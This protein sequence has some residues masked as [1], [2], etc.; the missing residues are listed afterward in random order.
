VFCGPEDL[1]ARLCIIKWAESAEKEDRTSISAASGVGGKSLGN[2]GVKVLSNPPG[3]AE[4]EE[5]SRRGAG[6]GQTI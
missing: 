6:P 3:P 4:T 5:G 2:R 1:K